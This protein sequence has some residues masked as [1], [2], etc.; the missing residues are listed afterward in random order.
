MLLQVNTTDSTTIYSHYW[1]P[2]N[3][4]QQNEHP[5]LKSMDSNGKNETNVATC[6]L[7]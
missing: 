7:I 1:A 4:M 3:D 5:Q 6:G 2:S